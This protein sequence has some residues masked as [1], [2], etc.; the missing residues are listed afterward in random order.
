MYMIVGTQSTLD[1]RQIPTS[2]EEPMMELTQG[3]TTTEES[4]ASGMFILHQYSNAC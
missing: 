1:Q 2:V 4:R 3:V